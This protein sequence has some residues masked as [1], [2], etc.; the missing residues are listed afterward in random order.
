MARLKIF[1]HDN[2]FDG[3][4]SAALFADFYRTAVD[5]AATLVLQGVQHRSGDPF[6]GLPFDGDD[7]ACVDFRYSPDPRLTWWFDHHVS[8]FQPPELSA[9]F[10]A[11]TSGRNFYDP[12]PAVHQVRGRRARPS[13]SACTTPPSTELVHWADIIDGAQFPTPAPRS[14]WP[15]RPCG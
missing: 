7:N 5:P 3:A 14:S 13:A 11:D 10:E 1:F 6:A 12:E 15:S 9:H 4:T 8:A 2:C